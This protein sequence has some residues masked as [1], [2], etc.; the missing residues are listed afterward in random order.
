MANERMD[1]SIDNAN[2]AG[3]ASARAGDLLIAG[4]GY[5]G[6]CV[7]LAVKVSAPHLGVTV[8]DLAPADAAV[9]DTRAS[10][11]AAAA[12]RML[13][14]LGVWQQLAADAQPINE[15]IVTDS[16]LNDPVRP[17]FLTFADEPT[18]G[19]RP[20]SPSRT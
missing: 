15:M 13:E 11:I 16:R 18:A 14:Q 19:G 20:A 2:N 7:A 1:S 6:L 9:N 17:V 4:G 5:V 10:A 12:S 3:E 8:V